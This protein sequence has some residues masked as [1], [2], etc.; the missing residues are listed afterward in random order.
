MK[1][2]SVGKKPKAWLDQAIGTYSKRLQ[3][4]FRIE[5]DYVPNSGLK[6]HQQAL[7]QESEQILKRLHPSDFV[8]LLDQNGQNIDSPQLAKLLT[9]NNILLIVGGAYGV[10]QTVKQRANF[11]WSLSK[12]VFPHQIVRLILTEQIYR[13]Q[14]INQ[15]HPYHH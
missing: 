13:A 4:N 10:D 6:S 11:T 14:T 5:W 3:G 1:I 15:N 7:K 2:I 9:N 12:L 8:I